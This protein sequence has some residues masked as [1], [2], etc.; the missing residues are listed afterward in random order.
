MQNQGR[1]DF[2]KTVALTPLALGATKSAFAEKPS[3]KKDEIAEPAPSVS[4]D[5]LAFSRISFGPNSVSE[6]QYHDLG[7]S[8]EKRFEKYVELQL[9]PEAIAD[10]AC[11]LRIVALNLKTLSQD[12]KSL[13]KAHVSDVEALKPEMKKEENK[14]RQQPAQEVEQAAWVRAIY[15][16]RQL[17]ERM[18]YF[19]HN[20]FNVYPWDGKI[21]ATFVQFDRDVIRR[22]LF[23]N[24]REFIEAV[25]KSP[26]MLQYLDNFTNQSG[27]PNENYARELFELHTLG[28]ENYLGTMDR[29]NVS[30]FAQG[31][32]IGYVDGDVYEAARCLTGWRMTNGEFEYFEGWHDRFQKIV[33]GNAIKEYQP[34]MKD[35]H[36]V[37]DLLANHPGTARFIARKLCRH[38]VADQPQDSLVEKVAKVFHES[39]K[40]KDQIRRT[41]RAVLLSEEFKQ[42]WGQKVKRPFEHTVS[43]LRASE[44]EFTPTDAFIRNH[45]RTG[46]RLFSWRTPDG[47]PDQKE[48]WLGANALLER[49][50]I[51]NFIFSG[52]HPEIRIPALE[53]GKEK[54]NSLVHLAAWEKRLLAFPLSA[55]ARGKI[56]EFSGVASDEARLR[57]SVALL[58]MSAE[59]QWR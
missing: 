13:W 15:S 5:T 20:H 32:P 44:A 11:L 54:I 25:T 18:A 14:L 59:A 33:L 42:S 48:K 46:E 12:S 52:Q 24:F 10:D 3:K 41:V 56:L 50:R 58:S 4:L 17:N 43:I 38:F 26:A 40:E 55:T 51:T 21:P 53:I 9:H 31:H 57:M 22:H 37:L 7:K 8:P 47:P 29:K 28:A 2:L 45:E 30:G 16:E 27:N 19:W 35:G 6:D 23:G 34:E 1:R 39:R 49:W 36:D